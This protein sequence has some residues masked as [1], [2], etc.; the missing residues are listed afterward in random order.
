MYWGIYKDKISGIKSIKMVSQR[1]P[2]LSREKEK[3][4]LKKD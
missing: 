3:F 1:L 4:K 2:R